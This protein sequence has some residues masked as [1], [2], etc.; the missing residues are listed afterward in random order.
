[1][2]PDRSGNSWSR[3]HLPQ[4]SKTE[5]GPILDPGAPSL[6]VRVIWFSF[7]LTAVMA[8][9]TWAELVGKTT[10][11]IGPADI[12][13]V[14]VTGTVTVAPTAGTVNPVLP[15]FHPKAEVDQIPPNPTTARTSLVPMPITTR[16]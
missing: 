14:L 12:P 5:F 15:S 7:G 1:M 8:I 10:K 4:T 11:F 2:S 16:E 6:L 9:I 13:T 3:N